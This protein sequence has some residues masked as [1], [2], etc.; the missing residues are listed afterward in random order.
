MCKIHVALTVNGYTIETACLK[1]IMLI[2]KSIHTD[3]YEMGLPSQE[4]HQSFYHKAMKTIV[5][6]AP[7][8]ANSGL[9]MEYLYI[10]CH[11]ALH[12]YV[13]NNQRCPTFL[14]TLNLQNGQL[15]K[16]GAHLI[17]VIPLSFDQARELTVH[18]MN[19]FELDTLEA[20]KHPA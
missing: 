14:Q 15:I 3:A 4:I 18:I 11:M 2:P 13:L 20:N 5:D 16:I 9:N 7:E 12:R 6:Q 17:K 8:S 1:D 19:A 10:A